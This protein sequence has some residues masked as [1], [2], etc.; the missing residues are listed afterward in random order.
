[1]NFRPAFEKPT[2]GRVRCQ[3][4]FPLAASARC[5]RGRWRSERPHR[6]TYV[7]G[8]Y[9]SGLTIGLT[10]T[11]HTRDPELDRLVIAHDRSTVLR[12]LDLLTGTLPSIT[13]YLEWPPTGKPHR[14]A[15]HDSGRATLTD[16]DDESSARTI[17]TKLTV[18]FAL[19]RERPRRWPTMAGVEW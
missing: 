11:A 14:E 12:L 8:F 17:Q 4:C 5:K 16:V 6:G 13:L 19:T 3:R 10:A 15:L 18:A 9:G 1:M 7:Y 2:G